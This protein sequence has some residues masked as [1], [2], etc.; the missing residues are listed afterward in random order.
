[1][2]LINVSYHSGNIYDDAENLLSLILGVGMKLQITEG[3]SP[4]LAKF[5]EGLLRWMNE[6]LGKIGDRI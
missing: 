3:D 2:P 6:E 5:K 1:M 4:E